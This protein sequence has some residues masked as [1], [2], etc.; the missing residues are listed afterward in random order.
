MEEVTPITL[1]Y[2]NLSE[3]IEENAARFPDKTAVIYR[4]QKLTYT[5]LINSS[6]QFA[7]YL[8]ASG[9][10]QGDIIGLALE[11]SIE[12]LICMLGLLR[13]GAV[14]VP[15]D[16]K[17]PKERIE[18]MLNDADAKMLLVARNNKGKFHSGATEKVI[19]DIWETLIK[20]PTTVPET[21]VNSSGLAYILYTSGSTGKPKGV[22]ITHV[23]LINLLT[24]V[25][26]KPGI[27][28]EDRLLAV[29]TISFDIAGLE[30][31]L[32]LI[33]G[34]ELMISELETARDGRLLLDMMEKENITI[35]QAT[36]STW[37]MMLDAGWNKPSPVKIF[38]GGEP[39]PRDLA[40]QLIDLSSEL[41]NMYGPT[42]T[43]IYSII[44]RIRKDELITIGQP[45]NHT[46][47]YLYNEQMELVQ[48]GETGEIFIGGEGVAAGYLN[49]PELTAERFLPDPFSSDPW[50]RL[51]K[52]GDLAR[53]LQNG[54][55]EYLGRIDQQVKIRGHRIELGEIENILTG[56]PQVKQA[57]VQAREDK[58][59]DK[60]LVA[61]LTLNFTPDLPGDNNILDVPR[62]VTDSFKALLKQTLPAYMVPNDYVVLQAFPLTPNYKIDKIALPV[63]LPKV[64]RLTIGH[65]PK[66]ENER[67]IATIWSKVLGV[68][69]VGTQDDFFDMGGNSMFAV[70]IMAQI[71]QQTGKRLP[72]S[73]LFENPTIGK[74]AKKMNTAEEEKWI[75][76]V[77]IKTTGTK[78]PLY[79]VH[80][81][82][83]NIILFQSIAKYLDADQPVYGL[84]AMGL[85]KPVQLPETVEEIAAVYVAEILA[86]NPAGPYCLAG[87]SLGGLLAWEMAKQLISAGREVKFLGILDT[88]A[89]NGD[90]DCTPLHK[91]ILK[92]E[93]QFKKIPFLIRSFVQH[94]KESASYQIMMVKHKLFGQGG[95]KDLPDVAYFSPYETEI[96]RT[97]RNAQWQ[98]KLA[99]AAISIHLFKV[100]KRLYFLADLEKLGWGRI[101]TKGVKVNLVPGDHKT[102]LYPPNE[103]EFAV[104]LQKEL[105]KL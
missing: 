39:L 81:G 6:N 71:E 7:N 93:R 89:G 36:P 74:L 16:P 61:Y 38:C 14:Y 57:L 25:Q 85:N 42:E 40:D 68:K 37:R 59:G 21:I 41:W 49:Q 78:L 20:Y 54:D 46:Q 34:A 48:D 83:L 45:I 27:T 2:Q 67:L 10:R 17:Y 22:K 88:Y 53:R 9:I 18:F 43:T 98:Y 87:Y 13:A 72:L 58:P 92:V 76:L 31:F 30:L 102:F 3:L 26:A 105:D 104:I 75:S 11:C 96:Y 47:I 79:L 82:G 51:Y 8:L 5:E 73:V 62:S 24:S 86:S 15:L 95:E 69:S 23:N 44:K 63:P 19:E 90:E 91:I 99:P 103:R 12:M 35:M 52:T 4:D 55:I 97:Y 100:K 70:R 64:S 80:G 94:P 65:L 101:A 33:T 29:T 50:A 60:K 56:H 84:Q 32:P 66:D 77:P 28:P 1:N